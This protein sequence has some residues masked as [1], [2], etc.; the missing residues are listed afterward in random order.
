M[1]EREERKGKRREEREEKGK[2]EREQKINRR[3]E[4]IREKERREGGKKHIHIDQ[5]RFQETV[6]PLTVC[7][8]LGGDS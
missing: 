4:M 6:L 5:A 7:R 3:E 8:G 2:D 1:R